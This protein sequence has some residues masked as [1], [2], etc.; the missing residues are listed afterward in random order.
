[1]LEFCESPAR[2]LNVTGPETLS[3][4]QAAEFFAARFQ[5]DLLIGSESRGVALINNAAACHAALG[6]PSLSAHELMEAVASWVVSGGA[7][8]QKATKFQITD[9]KF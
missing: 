8:L 7:S 1:M 6:Y 4:R 9:G 2:I 5:R 3:V